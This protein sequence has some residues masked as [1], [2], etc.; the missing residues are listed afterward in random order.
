VEA[1]QIIEQLSADSLSRKDALT[2][3]YPPSSPDHQKRAFVRVL[4]EAWIFLTGKT[5]GK[6]PDPLNNPFL[7][8][9]EAAWMDWHQEDSSV[10]A[11]FAEALNAAISSI[12][13][14]Q[15]QRLRDV[16]PEWLPGWMVSRKDMT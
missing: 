8:V 5:P 2:A 9:V 4:A 3:L 7:R 14:A 10:P 13:A 6:N 1:K 12:D 11:A 16:G 15:L